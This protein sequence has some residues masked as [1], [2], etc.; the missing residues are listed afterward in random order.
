MILASRSMP[1]L[2]SFAPAGRKAKRGQAIWKRLET[3]VSLAWLLSAAGCSP[4]VEAPRAASALDGIPPIVLDGVT[5]SG[6]RSTTKDLE[7][8]ARQARLRPDQQVAELREVDI[9]FS[10]S[11]RG[12]THVTADRGDFNLATQAFVLHENVNGEVAN[13]ERF[14]TSEVRYD[15]KLRRLHTDRPV[16]IEHGRI[17]FKGRGM[18]IDVASGRLTLNEPSGATK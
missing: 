7:V 10:D 9:K 18:V 5:F 17:S 8:R 4:V 13:G 14:A 6:Y 1:E 2:C 16:Q 12:P 15:E 3:A 11:E